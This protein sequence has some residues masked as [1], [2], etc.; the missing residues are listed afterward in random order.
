MEESTWREVKGHAVF[1][2]KA[3]LGLWPKRERIMLEMILG[4][5][6]LESLP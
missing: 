4:A 3:Y 1:M 6:S 2:V 5:F